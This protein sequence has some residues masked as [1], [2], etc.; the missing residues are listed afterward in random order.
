MYQVDSGG[1]RLAI[2]WL[3]VIKFT[4]MAAGNRFMSKAAVAGA[5]IVSAIAILVV[6]VVRYP[7][8]RQVVDP[9]ATTAGPQVSGA[10]AELQPGFIYGRITAENDTTY[11]G[12]LRWGGDQEAFWG[13]FFNGAKRENPWAVHAPLSQRPDDRRPIEIFG[14]EFGGSKRPALER[15]F[16]ARFGDLARVD[17][18]VRDVRVTL[19][20][21]TTFVLDRFEAG[22]M[23]DGVRVWDS[24]GGA[25]DLDA[26]GI[27]TIEFLAG[28][29]PA[30]VPRRLHGAVRTRQGTF[31]GFIQWNQQ[32]SVGSDELD[33]RTADG[34]SPLRYDTIRS[35]ARQ[36]RETA[37]VTLRD[38]RELVL[39]DNREVDHR[40]R[41]MFVDDPRYGRV[42]VSWDAFERVDFSPGTSGPG[43]RDFPPGQPLTGTVTARDG[44]RLT[45]RL[46]YDFDE[47]ETTETLDAPLPGVDY[48]IP[49]GRIASIVPHG[50]DA[51]AGRA[52][53]V[54]H[55]G[56]ELQLE[57]AGDLG[58]GNAGLL[59]FAAGGER[60]DHVPW[61]EVGQ[62]AFDRAPLP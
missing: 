56:E 54:L 51:G 13:D 38:G 40:N 19:K 4:A 28:A 49:F 34:E 37:L 24:R 42:L 43:Y 14:F 33:G 22:D 61:N 11:E 2:A 26:R 20:S 53:V 60:P 36:S 59:I 48:Y 50:G 47:S 7:P 5:V 29:P 30:D 1:S 35:I 32:D 21:G 46:V 9:A 16:M 17:A 57:R 55:D 18:Q 39:S 15:Q 45:G 44:R 27:R 12:R 10:A 3:C 62:I 41:G 6:L 23:D 58:D 8:P 52:T 31:T 25:V